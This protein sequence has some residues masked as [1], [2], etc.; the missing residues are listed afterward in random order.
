MVTWKQAFLELWQLT[1][2][3]LVSLCIAVFYIV[4][5]LY[6]EVVILGLVLGFTSCGM[7][8]GFAP[9]IFVRKY[10]GRA[11]GPSI[12][13]SM[14]YLLSLMAII[15]AF[16]IYWISH[17]F[18]W[19]NEVD[20]TVLWNV[21]GIGLVSGIFLGCTPFSEYKGVVDRA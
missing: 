20:K 9:M 13:V 7:Y 19:G 8:A 2:L 11:L 16:S 3:F 12:R 15:F 5:F 6:T 18:A 14:G 10:K 4:V 1:Q 21:W 17:P